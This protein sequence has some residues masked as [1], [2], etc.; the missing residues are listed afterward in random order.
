MGGQLPFAR[1]VIRFA[2]LIFPAAES[3]GVELPAAQSMAISVIEH[4]ARGSFVFLR[5]DPAEI[6]RAI[7]QA[8]EILPEPQTI[9]LEDESSTPVLGFPILLSRSLSRL[10]DLLAEF[11][12]SEED[13]QVAYLARTSFDSR[14]Y[15]ATWESY[16]NQLSQVLENATISSH[17]LDY[18]SLFW[19]HHSLSVA[20]N[21]LEVPK[22]IRRK[23]LAIGRDHG[24]TIKYKVFAK[25]MDRVAALT[26]DLAHRLADE[27]GEKEEQLFPAVLSLMRD[28]VLI[29]TEDYVSPDFSELASYFQ[30]CLKMDFRDIRQRL[31][32]VEEWLQQR[33]P[34]DP[35]L[36]AAATEILGQEPVPA[37]LTMRPGFLSFLVRHPSYPAA[38]LLSA[39]QA[40]VV[41]KLFDKLREFEILHAMRRMVVPV[42]ADNNQ[43][44]SRDRSINTTWVGGPPVL[45]LSTATRP[46]DFGSPW[47]VNPVVQRFGLIYDITDF[48]ATLSLLGRS[49]RSAL[50][51]AFRMTAHFQRQIN[52]LGFDL[53]VRLEKYLGDGAFYSGRHPRQILAM[54]IEIQRLYPIFV[55]RG[56]PFN[57]GL[58]VAMN[59]G[60]YRLL[61]LQE[62]RGG[63]TR[64]EFFGHGLVELSRLS[65]GKKTQEIDEFKTYLISQGYPEQQVN[66][67]FAPMMRRDSD[68]VSKLD[69]ARR[70]FAYINQ[71]HTLV[72]E[73]IVA[74]EPFIAR[75]GLFPQ[76]F[77]ARDH[78]RGF[79]V[80]PLDVDGQSYLL[81]VRKLGIGKFKGLEPMP[82]YEII[83][84]A[85]FTAADLKEIPQQRLLGALERLFTKTV[86]AAQEKARAT[87]LD[88][89]M[90]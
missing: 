11:V 8:D 56:Y 46:I 53:N 61:P 69:E 84:G 63:A 73:G 66:K 24:D 38:H 75:L 49:E 64:Y 27:M 80:V 21:L 50:E 4:L 40:Q 74:T 42:E 12:R 67:F 43:L 13:A 59:F 65:T 44:V 76:M 71:N 14:A 35:L 54:A 36:R 6:R 82:V 18:A 20:R 17:A 83:D 15:A 28:N 45:R 39:E 62:G 58:R 90:L 81:G 89:T 52:R 85:G 57:R 1:Y 9:Y 3:A 34:T 88:D 7:P 77:Y 60:E 48:S 55:D 68:L 25:W 19:L 2:K 72:N 5:S 22:R 23:D 78:G 33:L 51:E 31:R 47:V 37:L 16:K 70:F 29:L 41:E 30:G 79:I 10:N 26:Y 86:A 32:G 87:A